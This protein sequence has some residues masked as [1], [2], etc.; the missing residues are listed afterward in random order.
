MSKCPEI[1]R[2]QAEHS[3]LSGVARGMTLQEAVDYTV[4]DWKPVPA[5][6]LPKHLR[7][8]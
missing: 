3:I 5:S 4:E 2:L 6:S 8:Q 7:G 1:N